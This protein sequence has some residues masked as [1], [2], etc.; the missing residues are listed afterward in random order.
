MANTGSCLNVSARDVAQTLE[1]NYLVTVERQEKFE[2]V[3]VEYF[4]SGVK[5]R[6][7]Q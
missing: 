1:K 5:Q 2:C 4:D 7:R 6:Y 3:L